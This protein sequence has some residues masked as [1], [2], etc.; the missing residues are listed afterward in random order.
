M[1]LLQIQSEFA[2]VLDRYNAMKPMRVLEIGCWDGGT[3]KH[4][5]EGCGDNATVV[6]VDLDHRNREAY[7]EWRKA[8]TTL[9]VIEGNSLEHKT[10]AQIREHG[11]YDWVLIDG[12]HSDAAVRSDVD[13]CLPL[14]REGGVL[15]LHDIEP[16]AGSWTYPPGVLFAELREQG[17]RC[18]AFVEKNQ[19]P[20][21]HGLGLVSIP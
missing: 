11:P 1:E 14:I 2:P 15:L 6:A 10:I 13:V 16:P 7:E 3:L 19:D 20:W 18:E 17:Y 8:D 9:I 4:W 12:D 5:L 21:A